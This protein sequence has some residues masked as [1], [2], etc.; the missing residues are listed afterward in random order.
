MTGGDAPD[1][2]KELVE[3][4]ENQKA[5]KLEGLREME[6]L[7]KRDDLG[8]SATS[9]ESQAEPVIGDEL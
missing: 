4:S 7:S 2:W 9:G 5:A 3:E 6:E 1:S 8:E